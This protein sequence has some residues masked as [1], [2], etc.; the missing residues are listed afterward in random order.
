MKSLQKRKN[1][2]ELRWYAVETWCQ[3]KHKVKLEKE[4]PNSEA[5]L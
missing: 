2:V 4:F 1:V 3:P 5:R